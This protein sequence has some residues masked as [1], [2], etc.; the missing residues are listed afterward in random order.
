MSLRAMAAHTVLAVQ[1]LAVR[2]IDVEL[3]S[4]VDELIDALRRRMQRVRS[5]MR[6]RETHRRQDACSDR[7]THPSPLL[8]VPAPKSRRSTLR[9]HRDIPV[10]TLG[11]LRL[12]RRSPLSSLIASSSAF[13]STGL[14]RNRQ[15]AIGDLNERSTDGRSPLR[16]TPGRS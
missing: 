11:K 4:V 1:R 6:R 8:T 15:F 9:V 7:H 14:L 13:V 3:Q 16:M 5:G 12:T 10:N 2:R